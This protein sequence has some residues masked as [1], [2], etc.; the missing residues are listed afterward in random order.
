MAKLI[1][2]CN[3]RFGGLVY[4]K[5]KAE[6]INHVPANRWHIIRVVNKTVVDSFVHSYV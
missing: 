4:A 5:Q 3:L 1:N 6:I 2:Y